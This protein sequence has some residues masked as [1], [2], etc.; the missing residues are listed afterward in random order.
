MVANIHTEEKQLNAVVTS[1]ASS[2][3]GNGVVEGLGVDVKLE[4]KIRWKR[5]FI[6]LPTIGLLYMI[7]STAS[8]FMAYSS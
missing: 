8:N 2:S 4:R 6:L 3:I 7:V 1:D 5:D